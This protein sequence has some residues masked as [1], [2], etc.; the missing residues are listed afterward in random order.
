LIP[1][2]MEKFNGMWVCG[3]VN[4]AASLALPRLAR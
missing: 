2:S 1:Q 3:R 4:L